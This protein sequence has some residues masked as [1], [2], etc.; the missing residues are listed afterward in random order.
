MHDPFASGGSPDPSNPSIS[1]AT[2]TRNKL[3]WYNPCAFDNPP[4]AFPDASIK[5]S[6]VSNNKIIGLAALPYLGGRYNLVHG[7]GFER[8]NTSLFKNIT[9]YRED[10][11]QLRAD[12]FNVL[13]TPSLAN[14]ST[15]SN[16]TP[17]GLITGPQ[18]FQNFTPDARFIQLS[19]KFV[20]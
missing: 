12:I 14:P 17:G 13:N 7:P 16:A 6:P 19:A 8:I 10:Y 18:F 5:G 9:V 4:L 20:F 15:A 3:H 11:L 2:S 1:C